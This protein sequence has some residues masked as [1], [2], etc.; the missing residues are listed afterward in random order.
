MFSPLSM[1]LLGLLFK[2]LTVATFAQ[3]MFAMNI[4][5]QKRGGLPLVLIYAI[6]DL[7]IELMLSSE[8]YRLSP[9]SLSRL[10]T[11]GTGYQNVLPTLGYRIITI[12]FVWGLSTTICYFIAVRANILESS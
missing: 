11:L 5:F 12:P 7:S 9:V 8:F 6:A 1:Y 4:V 10:N 2:W 3:V